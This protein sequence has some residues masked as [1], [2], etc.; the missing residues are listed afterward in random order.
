VLEFDHAQRI[1]CLSYEVEECWQERTQE[2][3]VE[4][5]TDHGLTYRQVLA[6]D[7]TFSPQGATF[8]HEDLQLDLPAITHLSLT[9]VPNKSGSRW[10]LSR[11]FA[12]SPEAHQPSASRIVAPADAVFSAKPEYTREWLR[13][14]QRECVGCTPL[15]ALTNESG[16]RAV[17][18][19]LIGIEPTGVLWSEISYP[20]LKQGIWVAIKPKVRIRIELNGLAE[21]RLAVS[22]WLNLGFPSNCSA[23]AHNK[24]EVK[25]ELSAA[26]RGIQP[27]GRK[28]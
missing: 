2:A 8:Q 10:P 21:R 7:Y 5:S 4:V 9:I 12:F 19:L 18:E 17:E 28:F 15:H 24:W 11:R 25:R 16:A 14:V 6:Q 22:L 20:S 26:R 23:P 27:G 1:S 3:R 13:T